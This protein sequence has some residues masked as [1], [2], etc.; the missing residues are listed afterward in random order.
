MEQLEAVLIEIS[1]VSARLGVPLVILFLI[2][3][4]IGVQNHHTNHI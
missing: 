1:V 3:Y 2:G 4:I